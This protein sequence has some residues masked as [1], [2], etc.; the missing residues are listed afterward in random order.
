MLRLTKWF[1]LAAMLMAV[2]PTFAQG[3]GGGRQG[4]GFGAFG[5]FGNRPSSVGKY[6]LLSNPAVQNEL[7]LSSEQK[8]RITEL[9]GAL[10]AALQPPGG[11]EG[12]ESLREL[13]AEERQ[14]KL[15]ALQQQ[16][17]EQTKKVGA[18]YTPKF[19][20][21]LEDTQVTRLQQIYWQSLRENA[22]HD[23]EVQTH[24]NLSAEQKDK[25]A[26][27]NTGAALGPARERG[28]GGPGGRGPGGPG[29]RGPG[30]GRPE[31]R[32]PGGPGGAGGADFAAQ[33]R[34]RQEQRQNA[35]NAILTDDQKAKLSTLKG[36]EFDLSQLRPARPEGGQG[37]PQ[38]RGQRPNN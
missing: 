11:R 12:F 33:M 23:S 21:A 35:I 8:A 38:G 32:G 31:G 19:A 30:E 7:G 18:E 3:P 24:L 16:R 28:A 6:Q 17:E 29:G 22:V 1:A 25:L 2:T 27:L 5:A 37:R 10:N 34:E 4:G 20:E 13:P 36:S 15:T 26:A 14:Q 9:H